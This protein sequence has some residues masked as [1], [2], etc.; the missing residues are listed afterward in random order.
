MPKCPRKLRVILIGP[1][2][3]PANGMTVITESLVSSTLA[4]EF[5][6]FHLD[7]S[8]HRG[9][10]NINHIDVRNIWLALRYGVEFIGALLRHRPD[11]VHIQIARDRLGFLRDALFLIPSRLARRKVVLHLH[12]RDFDAFYRS[13]PWWVRAL[14]HLSISRTW[15]AVVLSRRFC[16][17]FRNF[18]RD[19]RVFVLPNGTPDPGDGADAGS[20]DPL[21]LHLSTLWSK[22]GVFDVIEAADKILGQV[23]DATFV[24]AG[25][26][27]RKDERESAIRDVERRGLSTVV[28]FVG[29]VSGHRKRALLA[30]ASALVFPTRSIEGQPVVVLEA[31]ASGTP[32]I[33]TRLAAI[34]DMV[35]DGVEGFLVEEG[36]TAGLAARLVD[37]LTDSALR[38]RLG[39]AARERYQRE[40]TMELF[41]DRVAKIWRTVCEV[42]RK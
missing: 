3:P 30:S 5:D 15:H 33:A 40:Y 34:P 8:D 11:V 18:I 22:K 28:N 21:V 39:R 29:P 35:R 20:R 6:L 31:L 17:T 1:L 37:V 13:Q 32:V 4:E 23:P 38:R 24:M 9:I 27:F 25:G 36:D 42:E 2:P 19:D 7:T 41:A 14:I 16:N 26:W 10:A 12:S